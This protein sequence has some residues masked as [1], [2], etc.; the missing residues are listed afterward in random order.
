MGAPFR[1]CRRETETRVG[2]LTSPPPR[3]LA[4][5]SRLDTPGPALCSEVLPPPSPPQARASLNARS[6][7]GERAN[8]ER[9]S[10]RLHAADSSP[11]ANFGRFGVDGGL[12]GEADAASTRNRRGAKGAFAAAASSGEHDK[13]TAPHLLSR[14]RNAE[15]GDR[16]RSR[17]GLDETPRRNAG[18]GGGG[19]TT[20]SG[21]RRG[22]D[23]GGSSRDAP[24]SQSKRDARRG[25]GPADEGG[26]RNVGMTREGESSVAPPESEHSPAD[27]VLL[28]PRRARKASRQEPQ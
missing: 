14:D 12:S 17:T 28:M 11:F 27:K 8:S 7:H 22:L 15:R 24:E 18:G 21:R 25:L 5:F 13:D 4:H 6:S 23:A 16:L 3:K 2:R 26:W 9:S 20:E 10:R 1:P 19:E